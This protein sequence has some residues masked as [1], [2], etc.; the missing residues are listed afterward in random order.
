MIALRRQNISRRP[1]LENPTATKDDQDINSMVSGLSTLFKKLN[2]HR[3]FPYFSV[4]GFNRTHNCE[5]NT[6]DK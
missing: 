4:I 5:Y 2:R 1:I 3:I 6:A